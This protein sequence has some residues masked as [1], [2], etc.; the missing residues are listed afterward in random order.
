MDL[1]LIQV[2]APNH[3]GRGACTLVQPLAQLGPMHHPEWAHLTVT[4]CGRR[5]GVGGIAV[6]QHIQLGGHFSSPCRHSPVWYRT[7]RPRIPRTCLPLVIALIRVWGTP[8]AL[9]SWYSLIPQGM[10]SA[11]G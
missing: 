7:T 10:G 8:V 5:P 3:A 11:R 1:Q 4:A 9:A 2:S 6:G